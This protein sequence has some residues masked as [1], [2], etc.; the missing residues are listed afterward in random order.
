[1][2]DYGDRFN[3]R[4]TCLEAV[5]DTGETAFRVY[6]CHAGYLEA[7]HGAGFQDLTLGQRVMR[8][9]TAPV[10]LLTVIHHKWGEFG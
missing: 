2:V 9:E 8:A 6:N 10:A 7:A 3:M 5:I 4:M 1:M